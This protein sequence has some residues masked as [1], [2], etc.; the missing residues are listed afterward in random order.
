DRGPQQH[1]ANRAGRTAPAIVLA[2]NAAEHRQDEEEEQE[3]DP[4]QRAEREATLLALRLRGS[5]YG[6]LLLLGRQL[7]V[8]DDGVGAGDD[9]AGH[10]ARLETRDDFALDDVV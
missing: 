9:A 3:A 6:R 2:A 1:V 7:E 10:V 5:C 4:D 8:A